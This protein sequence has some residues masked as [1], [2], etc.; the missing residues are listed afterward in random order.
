MRMITSVRAPVPVAEAVS[1]PPLA[2]PRPIGAGIGSVAPVATTAFVGTVQQGPM[3]LGTG[4]PQ[5]LEART[6]SQT[7]AAAAAEA[8]RAV[9]IRA[10]IAAGI[11]PLPLS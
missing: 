10:S 9:Y 5:L 2:T 7:T 1:Q 3:K 8:A 6:T 11:N 4:D